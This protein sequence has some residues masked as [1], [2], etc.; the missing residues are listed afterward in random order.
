MMYYPS[1]NQASLL[2]CISVSYLAPNFRICPLYI[3][4]YM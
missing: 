3:L 1:P 4:I 2:I